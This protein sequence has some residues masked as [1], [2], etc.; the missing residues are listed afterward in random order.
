MNG[1]S[2]NKGDDQTILSVLTLFNKK[3]SKNLSQH[4]FTGAHDRIL[5]DIASPV[6]NVSAETFWIDL[7]S[8]TTSLGFTFHPGVQ[9]N[10]KTASHSATNETFPAPFDS[11]DAKNHLAAVAALLGI[12]EK[13]VKDMTEHVFEIIEDENKAN[14]LIDGRPVHV[15]SLLGTKQLL[16]RVRDYHYGQQIDRIRIVTEAIRVE[17]SDEVEMDPERNDLRN[18]CIAFLNSLDKRNSWSSSSRE[19]GQSPF[20]RGLYQ[21]LVSLA[22]APVKRIGRDDIYRACELRDGQDNNDSISATLT[23]PSTHFAR[24]LMA[25]HL[26]HNDDA[27]RTESLVALFMLLYQRIDGGIDRSDY[28]LL[29]QAL[30]GQDFFAKVEEGGKNS[31]S[32]ATR[33]CQLIALILAECMSLWSTAMVHVGD[34]GSQEWIAS[35]PFLS[36]AASA[37]NEVEI[38]GRL[39]QQELANKVLERRRIYIS[40]AQM[41][42]SNVRNIEDDEVDAPEAIALLTFGLLMKLCHSGVEKGSWASSMGVKGLAV[43]CV[44]TA[45]DDCG[46][47]G[48]LGSIMAHLLPSTLSLDSRGSEHGELDL[49]DWNSLILNSCEKSKNGCVSPLKITNGDGSDVRPQD[50]EDREEDN[51]AVIYASIGREILVATLSAFRSSISRSLSS[52]KVDNLGMFCQLAAKL[53]RNSNVLCQRFWMDWEAT[54]QSFNLS[55]ASTISAEQADPLVFLLDIAHSVA[56]SALET[57]GDQYQDNMISVDCGRQEAVILPCLSP[58]LSFLASLI[59][60]NSDAATIF[61]TFIPHGMIHAC[62]LGVYHNCSKDNTMAASN[63]ETIDEFKRQSEA[64]QQC[65][66]ALCALSSIAAEDNNGACT[67]WLRLAT[68]NHTAK[69]YLEGPALLHA[70]AE[71]AN[72]NSVIESTIASDITSDVLC[73]ISHLCYNGHEN[74][75]WICKVG[76]SF[77]SVR[78]DGFRSFAA[79]VNKVTT[80][81]T[82]LLLQMTRS[83][84]GLCLA[85]DEVSLEQKIE[86]MRTSANGTLLACDIIAS[87]PQPLELPEAHRSILINAFRTVASSLRIM[88]AITHFHESDIIREEARS[89]LD[90]ILNALS[91]STS[92][93]SNVAFF[94]TIPITMKLAEV[95][96]LQFQISN[97]NI[98]DIIPFSD[99][100]EKKDNQSGFL[101]IES[102]PAPDSSVGNMMALSCEAVSLISAW[103]DIS[104]QVALESITVNKASRITELNVNE[105]SSFQRKSLSSVIMSIGPA[106][107]LFSS[108]PMCH[109][110]DMSITCF[111]LLVKY[112]VWHSESTSGEV[113]F[114][115]DIAIASLGIL[116]SAVVHAKL[117]LSSNL[118]P[119]L[120]ISTQIAGVQLHNALLKLLSDVRTADNK[121]LLL[122]VKIMDVVRL[123]ATNHPSL[124]KLILNGQLNDQSL[125]ESVLDV[126]SLEHLAESKEAFVASVCLRALQS[127]WGACREYHNN[128]ISTLSKSIHPCDDIVRSLLKSDCF[129]ERCISLCDNFST[130]VTLPADVNETDVAI[131]LHHTNLF[132][133]LRMSMQII[134][135]DAQTN[136]R[137]NNESDTAASIKFLKRIATTDHVEQWIRAIGS[138]DS[139]LTNAIAIK[140]LNDGATGSGLVFASPGSCE[141]ISTRMLLKH[142]PYSENKEE[143]ESKLERIGATNL[144]AISEYELLETV[145]GFGD[146]LLTSIQQ[147][148][149]NNFDWITKLA[150]QAVESLHIL[151]ET[152]LVAHLETTTFAKPPS[153]SLVVKCGTALSTLITTCLSIIPLSQEGRANLVSLLDKVLRSSERI[154]SMANSNGDEDSLHLRLNSISCALSLMNALQENNSEPLPYEEQQLYK[155]SRLGFCRFACRTLHDLRYATGNMNQNTLQQSEGTHMQKKTLL[156]CLS[157]MTTIALSTKVD[158]S[159]GANVF[160]SFPMDL[161]DVLQGCNALESLSYHLDEACKSAVASYHQTGKPTAEHPAFEAINSI[162][163][164]ALVLCESKEIGLAKLMSKG[165]FVQVVLRNPITT[166]A[167]EQWMVASNASISSTLSSRGYIENSRSAIFFTTKSQYHNVSEDPAHKIWVNTLRVFAGLLHST[168]NI[169][170]HAEGSSI[171]ESAAALAIDFL[172]LYEIPITSFI[173]GCLVQVPKVKEA[174]NSSSPSSGLGFTVATLN[175]LSDIMSLASELCSGGHQKQ[176]ENSSPRLY[177]IM[178]NAALAVCRSLSSFLGALGTAREIFFALN[179]LNDIMGK[180]STDLQ[181]DNFRMHPLL[182]DGVPNAKH[183]AIRNALYANSCCTCM[184]SEEHSLS[185]RGRVDRLQDTSEDLEQSFHSHVNNDFIFLIEEIASQ[186]IF[187]ALS[188]VHKVHPS[189][190]AFVTFTKDEAAH[191]NLSSIPPISAMV[192]IRQESQN[193]PLPFFPSV[194]QMIRHGRVIHYNAISKTLDVEYFDNIGVAAERHVSVSRL[195]ALED[196]SKRVNVFQYKPAP[197]SVSDSVA[198]NFT[199]AA[200]I[201]N[202][203]LIL[204]W[205]QQHAH[206]ST[207]T[208][209]RPTLELKGIVNLAS[210][211]LGNEIGVHLELDSPTFAS[212]HER[213][214]INSQLLLLFDDEVTLQNF[215]LSNSTDSMNKSA[216]LQNIIDCE[217]WKSV[218]SQLES[219]LIAARVDYELARKNAEQAGPVGAQYWGRRTPTGSSSRTNRRSPFS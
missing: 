213:K 151:A 134:E 108:A 218:Q 46:A 189:T 113:G 209:D 5:D 74:A 109:V 138:N 173:E 6:S 144:C 119:S 171:R 211:I 15:H 185:L 161:A 51:A 37:R 65:I 194:S 34:D 139:I 45:N 219:S 81:F 23:F 89:V 20:M 167:C 29:L 176:F 120:E 98:I 64:A 39:L 99:A 116:A 152:G 178:S 160:Q 114:F 150:E 101:S 35:H 133:I 163:T 58:L 28:V 158:D 49:L 11:N 47:F 102:L 164:F 214:S 12:P 52:A 186:C 54:P 95:T 1:P 182:A 187:S 123:S 202:L 128:A 87:S 16:L 91:T 26:S 206:K 50:D 199:G 76:Q 32:D 56:I 8:K 124:C 216:I 145:S 204:R 201:G 88:D 137:Y 107:L 143:F 183:Q 162:L 38:I 215:D 200:S 188:V 27:V 36:N 93:G 153:A 19:T 156:S 208:A 165:Q 177:T 131:I 96:N 25:D 14:G 100:D 67:E 181:Y 105:L 71:A 154:L 207:S 22:C 61:S 190:S 75:K 149:A 217:V 111:T 44:S 205:C 159:K 3:P 42:P 69:S 94:A 104:E 17:C 135:V 80:S 4:D 146:L 140:S 48:Y 41:M 112:C 195:A 31:E 155:V 175:E 85:V 83:V 179:S 21:I 72:R 117:D 40:Q 192:A 168:T 43:D 198:S 166:A 13:R 66:E 70:I 18:H 2:S 142:L 141:R 148:E 121:N 33:R 60:M 136:L 30:K 86:F 203:I 62:L 197:E 193:R 115:A 170:S 210:I 184:T 82:S 118:V 73:T 147:S 57:V 90:G 110:A 157:L 132:N 127:M 174:S 78:D 55:E 92:L 79:H 10:D 122:L 97:K 24:E 63:S 212:E 172:H 180:A 126:I 59:P 191:L 53:H 7:V 125:V 84:A 129:V 196:I 68:Q 169:G 9:S 103:N 130:L 106:R 77:S